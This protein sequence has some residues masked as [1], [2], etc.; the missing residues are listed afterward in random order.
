MT[1]QPVN[2]DYRS[3]PQ[4]VDV[5]ELKRCVRCKRNR[6]RYFFYHNRNFPDHCSLDCTDC[7]KRD[8]KQKRIDERTRLMNEMLELIG[9]RGFR[10]MEQFTEYMPYGRAVWVLALLKSR[11]KVKRVKDKYFVIGE[12]R[13]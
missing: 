2:C 3:C 6:E 10:R 7:R 8:R 9:V 12:K 1:F 13:K 11:G 5:T 4:V